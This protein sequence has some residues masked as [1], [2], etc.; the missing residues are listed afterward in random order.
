MN[1]EMIRKTVQAIPYFLLF[2]VPFGGLALL[3]NSWVGVVLATVI[4][5]VAG[6]A[7]SGMQEVWKNVSVKNT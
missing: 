6:L 2:F 3:F 5:G 1:D 4:S 7:G